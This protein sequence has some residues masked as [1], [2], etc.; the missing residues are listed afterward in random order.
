MTPFISISPEYKKASQKAIEKNRKQR[1]TFFETFSFN[2]C[3][4]NDGINQQW[5]KF[6]ERFDV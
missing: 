6:V 4:K 5:E 2:S 3:Q 1:K